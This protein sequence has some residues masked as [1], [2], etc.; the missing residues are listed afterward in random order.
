MG[1]MGS[2]RLGAKRVRPTICVVWANLA[3]KGFGRHCLDL[4]CL[5]VGNPQFC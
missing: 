1:S 5:G 3:F 2:D 4:G